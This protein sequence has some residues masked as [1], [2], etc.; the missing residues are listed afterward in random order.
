MHVLASLIKSAIFCPVTSIR[1]SGAI[2]VGE[3]AF[4]ESIA[5]SLSLAKLE[6]SEDLDLHLMMSRR[7]FISFLFRAF[8]APDLFTLVTYKPLTKL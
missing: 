1:S 4:R 2:V 3:L 5:I 8:F 6:L 7:L